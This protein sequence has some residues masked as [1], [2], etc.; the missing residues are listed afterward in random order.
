MFTK[1][2]VII[3]CKVFICDFHREKSWDRWLN[4]K[5]NGLSHIKNNVL[6][7]IRRIARSE[8]IEESEEAIEALKQSEV[9]QNSSKFNV[10]FTKYWLKIKEVRNYSL[11][12]L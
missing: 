7:Q 4:K 6:C 2:F 10:Y 5:D 8:T 1:I 3:D 12:I 9:W 11:H